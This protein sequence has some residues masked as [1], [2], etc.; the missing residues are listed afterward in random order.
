MAGFR[1]LTRAICGATAATTASSGRS[2]FSGDYS[3]AHGGVIGAGGICKH[4]ADLMPG[5]AV[6]D[7]ASGQLGT[8]KSFQLISAKS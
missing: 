4:G 8:G 3:A 7:A 2:Q 6:K 1:S 5:F